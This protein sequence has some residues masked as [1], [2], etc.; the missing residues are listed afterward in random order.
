MS[1]DPAPYDPSWRYHPS[2]GCF[3]CQ[4]HFFI[5]PPPFSSPRRHPRA[6]VCQPD[7][8]C[9]CVSCHNH[10]YNDY[11]PHQRRL[12]QRHSPRRTP[13]R[14]PQPM[15]E[16]VVHALSPAP[17]SSAIVDVLTTPLQPHPLAQAA[18]GVFDAIAS[19][20]TAIATMLRNH[21]SRRP[22][23]DHP[24]PRPQTSQRPTEHGV[25]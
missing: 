18:A 19:V 16:T 4:R 17:A 2:C 5:N 10:F 21:G 20:F 22:E 6:Q 24:S 13:S 7:P 3:P 9:R 23:N 14:S 15:P 25:I 8:S 1:C 12:I 11:R